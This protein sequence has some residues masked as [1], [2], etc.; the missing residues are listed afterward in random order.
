MALEE[1]NYGTD[2][3]LTLEQKSVDFTRFGIKLSFQR[4]H[5]IVNFLFL[6]NIKKF[7]STCFSAL[8]E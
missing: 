7:I 6:R 5:E 4:H 3:T 2:Q 8:T 1:H